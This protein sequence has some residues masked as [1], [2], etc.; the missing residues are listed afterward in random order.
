MDRQHWI[1]IIHK[2]YPNWDVSSYSYEQV[3]AI[4]LS[5]EERNSKKD[6][7]KASEKI[8]VERKPLEK[9]DVFKYNEDDGCWYDAAGELVAD[10]DLNEY[11]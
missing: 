6:E 9:A 3:K 5:L 11:K 4:A 2:Y 10:S 8:M 1:N 7:A